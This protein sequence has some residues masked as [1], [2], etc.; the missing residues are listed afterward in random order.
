MEIEPQ[1]GNADAPTAL[2]HLGE[3]YFGAGDAN[4]IRRTPIDEF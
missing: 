3:K 1:R 2:G 4:L